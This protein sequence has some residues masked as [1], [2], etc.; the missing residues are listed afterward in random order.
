LRKLGQHPAAAV[1]L[2]GWIGLSV[3]GRFAVATAVAAAVGIQKPV[4]AAVLILPAL[5]VSGLI[6][7][8]PGNIGIA[9]AAIAVAFRAHG[10]SFSHGLAAG[11]TLQALE[12][13]VG[14]SIDVVRVLWLAPYSSPRAP[15]R[16]RLGRGRRSRRC[17]RTCFST[18][19]VGP[20]TCTGATPD[21][22]RRCSPT[23]RRAAL[24]VAVN[25][26]L[27]QGGARCDQSR[28]QKPKNHRFAGV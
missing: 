28:Q 1:R 23:Q 18:P 16:A 9:S 14:L 3:A 22:A 24:P 19:G 11:I 7:L 17:D 13:A 26:L 4:V 6:P 21:G 2:A 8:T 5:D 20:D 12:T 15:R 10:V 27:F 25:L